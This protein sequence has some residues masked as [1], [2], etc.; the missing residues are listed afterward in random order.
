MTSRQSKI[1]T[2]LAL[3]PGNLLRVASYR[4]ALRY[5]RS[6]IRRLH[7]PVPQGPFFSTPILPHAPA[8]IS[9]DW[10]DTATYF[11]HH[12]FTLGHAAPDWFTN[13]FNGASVSNPERPWWAIPDFDARLGDI[14]TVWEASRMDWVVVFS[15]RA[16]AGDVE[17]LRKLECW[18]D[19][20]ISANQ[21]YRG[22][23]WKCGQEASIRVMHMALAALLL[24]TVQTAQNGIISLVELHL[25]RIAPTISYAQ[26]QNNNHGT[27]EAAALFIGGSWLDRLGNANGAAWAQTGRRML[28]ERVLALVE[29]DG[30]FSQYSTNYHRLMLDTVSL[31]EVWRRQL[32]LTDFS[33]ALRER[34]AAA[35]KWLRVMTADENGAAANIGAN[36]GARLLPLGPSPYH[37]FRPSVQLASVLFAGQRSYA[38]EGDWNHYVQWLGVTLPTTTLE[39]E[40][41][42][43]LDDGGYAALVTGNSRALLRYPRFRFRPS[44]ADALH[45]DFWVGGRNILR[46]GGTLTY[47]AANETLDK[48]SGTEGHNTIQ[49]DGRNQMTRIS[50]FLFADWLQTESVTFDANQ[51]LVEASYRDAYGVRH[52]RCMRQTGIGQL[53]I[54]DIVSGPFKGA[55]L[56]WRLEPGNWEKTANGARSSLGDIAVIG[57]M[58]MV[59][60]LATGLESRHYLAHSHLPVLEVRFEKSG[61]ISTEVRVR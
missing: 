60:E 42:R 35:A 15:Q 55:C 43:L 16:V 30:S 32:N 14:K 3:G 58:P 27:S 36:D 23:N 22:P 1:R 20:W 4:L 21:P 47:N 19:S 48:F 39:P 37:D 18:L 13:P 2:L 31:A 45:V 56:R 34:A 28:E 41:S 25:K 7:A 50:R 6:S 29:H 11:G 59:I 12:E 57:D 51:P 52:S 33:D 5:P 17:A 10:N 53:D 40:R 24:G 44:H 9:T 49:F 54:T 61:T 38:G 46:D 26:A 8:P